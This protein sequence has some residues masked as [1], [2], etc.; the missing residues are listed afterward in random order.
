[1]YFN[2][3]NTGCIHNIWIS[4]LWPTYVWYFSL[5]ILPSSLPVLPYYSVNSA[6]MYADN[7][8]YFAASGC[9]LFL[10]LMGSFLLGQRLLVGGTLRFT[11]R[12]LNWDSMLALK[13]MKYEFWAYMCLC[14]LTNH[15]VIWEPSPCFVNFLPEI[16]WCVWVCNLGFQF[17]E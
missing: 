16:T 6:K 8:M 10:F 13:Y 7:K 5:S 2:P 9:M 4:S 11:V 17:G 12:L 1:M 3:S 15:C 14:F